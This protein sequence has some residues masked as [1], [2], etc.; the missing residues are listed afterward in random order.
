PTHRVAVNGLALPSTSGFA[1]PL[2]VVPLDAAAIADI[3]A[4][5]QVVVS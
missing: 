3:E 2:G 5:P 4:L 1:T